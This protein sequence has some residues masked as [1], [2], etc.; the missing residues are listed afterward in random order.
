MG[1]YALLLALR[2]AHVAGGVM[3]VGAAVL[4]A[5]FVIPAAQ[6]PEMGAF[7]QRMMVGRRAQLYLIAT[8]VVTVLSGVALYARMA[9][10]TQGSYASTDQGMTFGIGGAAGVVALLVGALVNGSAGRQL[11]TLSEAL[12]RE[13][14]PPTPEE[15]ARMAT[16]QGR[17][18]WASRVAMLLLFVAVGCMAVGRYV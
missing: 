10:M 2:L 4:L 8:A 6:G 3:W 7:M 5:G 1:D 12:R 11:V 13:G 18:R 17:M 16:L 15:A 9:S 14:R